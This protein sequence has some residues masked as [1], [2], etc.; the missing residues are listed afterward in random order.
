MENS[1]KVLYDTGISIFGFDTIKISSYMVTSL[2]ITVVLC[3]LALIVKKKCTATGTPGKFQNVVEWLVGGIYNF[4]GE[5]IGE[6]LVE[7]YFPFIAT[8]FLFI[9]T[10]NY[11]GLLP[12]AG[13]LPGYVAPTSTLG[14][15]VGLAVVV[16]LVTHGSG[17]KTHGVKYLKHFVTPYAF[18]LPLLLLEE[19]IRPTS[20]ALRL[21]GN[22][23]GED[24][25]LEQLFDLIPLGVPIF[26]QALG[27][28]F[29]FLQALVFTILACVYI[30]GAAEG[31]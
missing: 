11:V 3:L 22:V 27:L 30:S 17:V 28:L 5:I 18:L 16:F 13:R 19:I 29:G 7:R 26:M 24:T 20:L 14:V 23:F 15:T 12:M 1:A 9:L 2:V 4:F 6:E 8:M 31:H 10:S 21:Y 25:V